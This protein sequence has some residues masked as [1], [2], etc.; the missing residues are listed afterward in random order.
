MGGNKIIIKSFKIK[1]KLLAAFMLIA[2]FMGAVGYIGISSL[3]KVD[4]NTKNIY[5][6]NFQ[7]TYIMTD[8]K[9]NLTQ[10][11][12]DILMLL[13]A[14]DNPEQ[15]KTLEQ[16]IK[17]NDDENSVYI[18]RYEKMPMDEEK[19]EWPIFKQDLENYINLRNELVGLIDST[20]AF[21]SSVMDATSS[22][23][24]LK[25]LASS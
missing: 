19:K 21:I 24:L 14:R 7:S 23:I 5:N 9:D 22:D 20:V 11:R 15:N 4:S 2:L 16:N 17:A 25:K 10:I 8:M 13:Y 1:H 12:A 6:Y 3:G 18:S